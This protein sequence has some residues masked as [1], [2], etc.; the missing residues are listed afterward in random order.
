MLGKS[1]DRAYRQSHHSLSV[2]EANPETY[3]SEDHFMANADHIEWLQEGADFWNA[4]RN[5]EEAQYAREGVKNGKIFA[6][7]DLS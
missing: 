2:R 3:K 7:R 6:S 4:K 5:E 1:N